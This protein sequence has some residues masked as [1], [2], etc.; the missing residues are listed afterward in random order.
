MRSPSLVVSMC[1]FQMCIPADRRCTSHQTSAT[2]PGTHQVPHYVCYKLS[3][4]SGAAPSTTVCVLLLL[5]SAAIAED[6]VGE[7]GGKARG[8]SASHGLTGG[9]RRSTL[10]RVDAGPLSTRASIDPRPKPR[11]NMP[12]A[13]AV[14]LWSG[15]GVAGPCTPMHSKCRVL[16]SHQ[17]RRRA[18]CSRG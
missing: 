18:S 4:L 17:P 1:R 3:H 11:P 13:V 7:G 9:A 5:L 12:S 15:T 14:V 6:E 8:G 16:N 2:S 10:A